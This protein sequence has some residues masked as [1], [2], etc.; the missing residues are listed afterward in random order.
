LIVLTTPYVAPKPR[1]R[2]EAA[3]RATAERTA[4]IDVNVSNL[5]VASFERGHDLQIT[6]VEREARARERG[7]RRARADRHRQRALERSRRSANRDQYHLSK[8]QAKRARRRELAGRSPQQV[9]P[10]G[11]RKSRS[12]GKP[13]QSYRKD[14]L[15]RSY[16][17]GR[18]AQAAEA[19]SATRARRDHARQ[20][21]ATLVQQHGFQLTVED[22][23]VSAWS[24]QW[25]RSL[26]AF[27]PA[28][29]L[30]AIEREAAAVA[31]L[32]GSSGGVLR[33]STRTTALSQHCLCGR[34]VAKPLSERV[35]ACPAC[36]L[37]GD[38]DAV[39]AALGAYVVF[40]NR[41]EPSSATV[42]FDAARASLY[43]VRTRE[44]MYD[45]L[46]YAV[47]G[48][49]DALSESTAHAARDGWSVAETGRTLPWVVARR[50][51]G[52]APCPTP[53][54]P[55]PRGQTT[56]E[57]ARTRTNLP[58]GATPLWDSS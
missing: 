28:T 54:E 19:A 22:C 32:A 31:H 44:A 16:R 57:R 41:A 36:G 33:A 2:R 43:D 45:T 15:S 8:R 13:L 49:Q 10:G 52:T 40:A 47:R 25:G 6:R 37:R 29:L 12:D 38:R 39:S 5:T 26:A 51:V 48:R 21:A 50:N 4:G 46:A 53:D 9:I 42:D 58:R 27:S 11:A 18:A 55:G 7:R 30:S 35:H 1:A 17:R 24:A 14:Q 3:A 34:R 20:V 23:D 56:S